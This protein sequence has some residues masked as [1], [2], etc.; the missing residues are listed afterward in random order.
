[1]SI[2]SCIS[3]RRL[4]LASPARAAPGARAAAATAAKAKA[5]PAAE[6]RDV[7]VSKAT[8][9]QAAK[10]PDTA[11]GPQAS[12]P[13]ETAEGPPKQQE[14]AK[15]FEGSREAQRVE[16]PTKQCCTCKKMKP[17]SEMKNANGEWSNQCRCLD[18]NSLR[19]RLDRPKKHDPALASGYASF[20]DDTRTQ[21]F[22]ENVHLFKDDLKK[23][24]QVT[25]TKCFIERLSSKLPAE[26]DFE[27]Y[28][29][30]EKK[31]GDSVEFKELCANGKV[32][33]HPIHANKKLA[34]NPTYKMSVAQEQILEEEHTRTLTQEGEREVKRQK[35]DQQPKQE[36]GPTGPN[37]EAPLPKGLAK[38]LATVPPELEAELMK[39]AAS[40]EKSKSE[41]FADNFAP[42]LKTRAAKTPTTAS[43]LIESLNALKV[44]N[45]TGDKGTVLKLLNDAKECQSLLK[46]V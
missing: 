8:S 31:M 33:D 4:Q 23:A 37:E 3:A 25:I 42:A 46:D 38:R 35:K 26:G 28:D 34:W 19:G 45:K 6:A 40:F 12:K 29:E 22:A 5:Q 41:E 16:G 15:G 21:F 10:P 7:E 32:I 36:E 20:S 1:M 9:A 14:T 17:E 18:C 2:R 43:K 27:G 13:Q 44:A 24:L 39:C 30:L 11:K